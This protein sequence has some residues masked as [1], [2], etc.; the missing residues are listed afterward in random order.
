MEKLLPQQF[1]QLALA[2]AIFSLLSGVAAAQAPQPSWL[3][4]GN[5]GTNPATNFVGTVDAQ[6][7]IFRTVGSERLRVDQN[8]HVGIGTTTPSGN[9]EVNGNWDGFS[10]AL[11]LS[12]DR[13]TIRFSGGPIAGSQQWILHEGSDGPGFLGFLNGGTT[14]LWS[15]VMT[16]KPSGNV[17]VIGNW[18]GAEGALTLS[19]DK[20]TI[21]FSGGPIAGSQQWILH[22]GS[23]GPGHLQ[24]FNGG[25]TGAWSVVMTLTHDGNVGIGTNNPQAQLD[26][27][28]MTRTGVLQIT[29]GTDIAEPF[30][31][32]A[33][34]AVKPGMV[35]AI[36]PERPGHLRIA[37]KAY[38]RTV[39]GIVSGA[40]GIHPGLTM[41]QEG[42]A[43]D[44]S[45]FV[46][47]T[48]R[49]YCWADASYDP[50]EP[51]DLL[52]TSDT[53]GHATKVTDHTKA[54]GATIGKAMTELKQGTGLVLVLVALQ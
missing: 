22:E 12:G 36:D 6:P 53:P 8:G 23:D 17:G 24:F 29:G 39:A 47:L 54:Q 45:I 50:I 10:G 7:L 28:G 40:N 1:A 9:L 15:P 31:I 13:P 44:K 27:T 21:R 4:N 49:V 43:A 42:T 30:A 26:V 11:T 48:G 37:N 14:G 2:M 51:G 41:K 16:L 5:A 52:T 34:E 46:A 25:T 38:D 33:A 18:N 35:V 32:T 19:G 3:L 20:P